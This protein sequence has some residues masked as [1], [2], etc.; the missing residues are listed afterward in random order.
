MSKLEKLQIKNNK[1]KELIELSGLYGWFSSKYNDRSGNKVSEDPRYGT[2][3]HNY[4]S[5]L[6]NGDK[7]ID[8]LNKYKKTSY[9]EGIKSFKFEA[10]T[11]N[12]K[13]NKLIQNMINI[14]YSIENNNYPETINWSELN[15]LRRMQ[16]RGYGNNL[17][18]KIINEQADEA[19]TKLQTELKEEIRQL[20]ELTSKRTCED[21]Y[22]LPGQTNIAS[23]E[24]KLLLEDLLIEEN[25]EGRQFVLGNR[26]VTKKYENNNKVLI[27]PW[28]DPSKKTGAI[29]WNVMINK[30]SIRCILQ[31]SKLLFPLRTIL[32]T[33][34]YDLLYVNIKDNKDLKFMGFFLIRYELDNIDKIPDDI[35][36]QCE[37]LYSYAGSKPHESKE[38][39]Y[40][41]FVFKNTS[42]N[43][44]TENY[45]PG[46]YQLVN[47][48]N[49]MIAWG[50][51]GEQR[52]ILS[53]EIRQQMCM[54]VHDKIQLYL[55]LKKNKNKDKDIDNILKKCDLQINLERP[56]LILNRQKPE[57]KNNKK[58]NFTECTEAWYHS[59]TF[60]YLQ[61]NNISLLTEENDIHILA[62]KCYISEIKEKL[63]TKC[64]IIKNDDI[65]FEFEYNDEFYCIMYCHFLWEEKR[66]CLKHGK[67]DEELKLEYKKNFCIDDD[68]I[69]ERDNIRFRELANHLQ[70]DLIGGSNNKFYLD[71]INKIIKK[72]NKIITKNKNN[73]FDNN[74]FYHKNNILNKI[75][76]ISRNTNNILF[77]IND[78]NHVY[79]KGND[80]INDTK[81]INP[82]SLALSICLQYI[83][84]NILLVT[85]NIHFA[86]IILNNY[87]NINITIIVINCFTISSFILLKK[88]YKNLINIYFAGNIINYY[89]YETIVKI[90]KNNK[91]DT[92]IID[93]GY[94]YNNNYQEKI[95]A[96]SILLCN[97]FLN[98]GGNLI[99]YTFIP[100]NNLFFNLLNYEYILFN[101]HTYKNYDYFTLNL[102]R[103]TILIYSKFNK[104]NLNSVLNDIINYL[105]NDLFTINL[106]NLSINFLKFIYFKIKSLFIYNKNYIF[107]KQNN[108]NGGYHSLA[109]QNIDNIIPVK[110]NDL[111]N[112][113]KFNGDV[114]DMAPSCHWGQK[115]LLFSEIQFLTNVCKKLNTK[116]LKD[117]AVVYVGAAH[118]FHFPILYNL[119]PELIWI[120]YD[121]G[122]F[123]KE[124]YMHPEKQK[125]K[126]FNQFFTDETI[127]HAQQ[128]AENRKILFISDIRVTPKDEQVSLDMI[129]QA[130]W[131]ILMGADFMLLKFR[132]PYNEPNTFKPKTIKDLK[133]EKKFINNHD[134]IAKDTI[135]LKGDIF[136]QLYHPQ[137]STEL[138]LFVEKNT[139]N[140]Y[141]L[142][143]YDYIDVENKLFKYNSEIRL[144]SNIE[145]YEF[146]NIIPGYDDS[147]ECVMEYEIIKD[148]YEYFHNIKDKNIII[149]KLYDLNYFLEKLTHKLFITCN[150]IKSLDNNQH[151]IIK[152]DRLLKLNIWKEIIQLNISISAKYQKDYITKHG[153]K[154]IGKERL[155]RSLKFIENFITK[156]TYY[157]LII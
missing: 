64:K 83:S 148:Y 105:K 139:N 57:L 58:K 17:A 118:G 45:I 71:K 18:K 36:K 15:K 33:N 43:V 138:R 128:N 104:F 140:K 81:L 85:C 47:F 1:R 115:K 123:S 116:S 51:V 135:Y 41:M 119:F 131:G 8:F 13:D 150:I 27:G 46:K 82:Q 54:Y 50:D 147:L 6:E 49:N 130:R 86:D 32:S 74:H 31:H 20:Y 117:Y 69:L 53:L 125:V 22:K 12:E 97:Q 23:P 14:A 136:L 68:C 132:L 120:L 103:S 39:Y 59:E 70:K 154:I 84:N 79:I 133:L 96:L 143:N 108:L 2:K 122:K 34:P 11:D 121:P 24:N 127:K 40:V 4:I 42:D 62:S 124:S 149:R 110:I 5:D 114:K 109:R 100:D 156:Q 61:D 60:K 63:R 89:L 56:Q 29:A 19:K 16:Y 88:K 75:F 21:L 35:A 78:N 25:I 152:K 91:Y 87:K 106:N 107:N 93:S 155:Q 73:E 92:I 44:Y 77:N 157:E 134:F 95:T 48:R 66:F 129:N 141:D 98:K 65:G 146:L 137:Y 126:I 37:H 144:I 3:E 80:V 99:K 67:I 153:L 72:N 101:N 55:L 151:N 76:N 28:T 102:K 113:Y 90:C 10:F 9:Y 94:F 26:E 38:Q 142:Q 112:N 111:D 145:G 7:I 52:R 30:S